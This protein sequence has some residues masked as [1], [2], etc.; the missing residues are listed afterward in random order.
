MDIPNSDDKQAIDSADDDLAYFYKIFPDDHTPEQQKEIPRLPLSQVA[1]SE[2][3]LSRRS[4][5][6]LSSTVRDKPPG[7]KSPHIVIDMVPTPHDPQGM[8][9]D[10]AAWVANLMAEMQK[11][12]RLSLAE[13]KDLLDKVPS[14]TGAAAHAKQ[15]TLDHAK[16]LSNRRMRTSLYSAMVMYWLTF[17]LGKV[18]GNVYGAAMV[19]SGM[20]AAALYAPLFTMLGVPFTQV[21]FGEPYGGAWR[22]AGVSYGSPDQAAYINYQTAHALYVRAWIEGNTSDQEKYRK[23]MNNIVDGLIDREHQRKPDG[24]PR[25]PPRLRSNASKPD[26]HDDG[27]VKPGHV[28]PSRAVVGA[29]RSR[30]FITDEVPVHTFTV[31]NGLSGAANLFWKLGMSSALTRVPDMVAHTLMGSI[32]MISMFEL[33]NSWRAKYQ[34]VDLAD[35]GH[36]AVLGAQREAA[37]LTSEL[38]SERCNKAVALIQK[39]DDMLHQLEVYREHH[40]PEDKNW[41]DLLSYE[42]T[43]GMARGQLQDALKKMKKASRRAKK[44]LETLSTRNARANV[45]AKRIL[46]SM[47]GESPT[48]EPWLD[49][50][51]MTIRSISRVLGYMTVLSTSTAQAIWLGMSL[52]EYAQRQESAAALATAYNATL[53]SEPVNAIGLTSDQMAVATFTASTVAC[54]AIIGWTCKTLYGL[55]L[56]EHGINAVAGIATR[57]IKGARNSLGLAPDTTL[58][59]QQDTDPANPV[60]P[61]DGPAYTRR[62]E[63]SSD[64]ELPPLPGSRSSSSSSSD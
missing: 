32:A 54:N 8:A 26:R 14:F 36:P 9:D 38:W 11:M 23:V 3:Q 25:I 17:G 22:S 35:G 58:P 13:T 64:I 10:G 50:A 30:S 47:V 52:V 18:V 29:A 63:H 48:P 53:I 37:R 20:P 7:S 55:P 2:A 46:S 51:P 6:S 49:G 4:R 31:L 57:A 59:A 41:N 45:A 12:S 33:Q 61:H 21:I 24:S 42:T 34:G 44:E 60:A 62:D 43:L 16:D 39:I 40:S 27:T 15:D 28:D 5:L 19:A 56:W 1:N